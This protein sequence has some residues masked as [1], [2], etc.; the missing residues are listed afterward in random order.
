MPDS[1]YKPS[2][3][4][5]SRPQ[6]QVVEESANLPNLESPYKTLIPKQKTRLNQSVHKKM[7]T[8]HI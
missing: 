5:Q 1:I 4:E 6:S 2:P 3:E 8:K 7:L